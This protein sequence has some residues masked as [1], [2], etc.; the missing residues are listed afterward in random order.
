MV[1]AI[2]NARGQ[3]KYRNSDPGGSAVQRD[4]ARRVTQPARALLL[5]GHIR[6]GAPSLGVLPNGKLSVAV[7]YLDKF[8]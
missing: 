3:L 7:S 4:A 1:G 5:R 2:C 6:I 8:P